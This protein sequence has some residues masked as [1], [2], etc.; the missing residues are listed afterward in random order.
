MGYN[1]ALDDQ[2][3]GSGICSSCDHVTICHFRGEAR[4][5]VY[6]CEEFSFLPAAS[7]NPGPAACAGLY[8]S[9]IVVTRS[10]Q[11]R[12]SFIGLCKTCLK[13]AACSYLKP[14]GGTWQC[15]T[16]ENVSKN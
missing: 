10:E 8:D 1:H 5:P 3:S 2:S 4:K 11:A 16:Y 7:R 6:Y 15:D 13:L 12:S 14:G 9:R